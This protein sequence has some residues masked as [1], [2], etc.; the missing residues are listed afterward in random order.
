MNRSIHPFVDQG[1]LHAVSL[2][3]F[4]KKGLSRSVILESHI[5]VITRLEK[6]IGTN[7]SKSLQMEISSSTLGG[8][9]C[10]PST[11]DWLKSLRQAWGV[12]TT[13]WWPSSPQ[14]SQLSPTG[15]NQRRALGVFTTKWNAVIPD[16]SSE[17]SPTTSQNRHS[18]RTCQ[19]PQPLTP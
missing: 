6:S 5:K 2:V 13:G 14:L 12:G 4:S 3:G 16:V 7:Y 11:K 9:K 8:R 17:R 19:K 15:Q 10:E 18:S 1:H